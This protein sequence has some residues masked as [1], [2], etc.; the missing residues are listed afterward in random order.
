MYCTL[1]LQSQ[2]TVN[3]TIT[4]KVIDAKDGEPLEY[5]T[6]SFDPKGSGQVIGAITNQKGN[7]EITVP[8]NKYTITVEFLAG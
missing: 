8:K 1:H 5:A 6:I 4:G 3:Y 7:F 2:E